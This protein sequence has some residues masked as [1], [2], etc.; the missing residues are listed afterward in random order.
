MAITKNEWQRYVCSKCIHT[1]HLTCGYDLEWCK[2]T[3]RD[4]GKLP[5]HLKKKFYS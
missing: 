1:S 3:T 2:T 5:A 4:N